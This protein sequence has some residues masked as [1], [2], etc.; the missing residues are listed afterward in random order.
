MQCKRR[1]VRTPRQPA[2]W[3]ARA[4]ELRTAPMLKIWSDRA[5]FSYSAM[6]RRA[7]HTP[8]PQSAGHVGTDPASLQLTSNEICRAV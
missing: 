8:V 4:P 5:I 3:G 6:R 1:R 2:K 7:N